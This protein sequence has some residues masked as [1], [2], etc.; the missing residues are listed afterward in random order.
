MKIQ[1]QVVI[2]W[3]IQKTRR[4]H[5]SFVMFPAENPMKIG[6]WR[7]QLFNFEMQNPLYI[8]GLEDI[9]DPLSGLILKTAW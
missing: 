1:L 2:K 7:P 5:L 8:P 4:I 3:T 6:R 9:L